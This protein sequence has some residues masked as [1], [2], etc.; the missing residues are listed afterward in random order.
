MT[1]LDSSLLDVYKKILNLNVL[2]TIDN[3]IYIYKDLLCG[4]SLNISQNSILNGNVS[5]VS[6]LYISNKTILEDVVLLNNNLYNLNHNTLNNITTNNNLIVSNNHITSNITVGG[7]LIS[8]NLSTNSLISNGLTTI[9]SNIYSNN[10]LPIT[11]SISLNS[12]ILN[13]GN[14]N[15][16]ININGTTLNEFSNELIVVD[17]L[18]SINV[19]YS[20]RSGI[21]IG[22]Q[23]GFEIYNSSGMGYFKTNINAD[24]YE[25]K[26]PIDNSIYNINTFNTN[27][28]MTITGST[29]FRNNTNIISNLYISSNNILSLNFTN[30]SIF[31]VSNNS[32]LN[33]QASI[34]KNISVSSFSL[35][36]SSTTINNNLSVNGN[37]SLN[38]KTVMSKLNIS[39]LSNLNNITISSSIII[40]NISSYN[41]LQNTSCMSSL[42]G[43]NLILKDNST[44]QTSLYNSSNSILLGHTSILSNC[45]I[46]GNTNIN[47]DTKLISNILCSGITFINSNITALSNINILGKITCPLKEYP[48]NSLATANGVPLWGFYRTGG[49]IKIRI[50]NISPTIILSGLSTIYLDTGNNYIDQGVSVTDNLNAN[51]IPYITSV[52][53]GTTELINNKIIANTSNDLSSIVNISSPSNCIITYKATDYEGNFSIKK[54]QLIINN[55]VKL[56]DS[57]TIYD[58]SSTIGN[59]TNSY[60]NNIYSGDFTVETWIYITQYLSGGTKI[61]N[62]TDSTNT[63]SF[64]IDNNGYVSLY[65]SPSNN[66]TILSTQIVPL[67]E[68]VHIVW[69]RKSGLVYSFINGIIS[70]SINLPSDF[71]SLSS[72]NNLN[73]GLLYGS[74]SQPL[75]TSTSKYSL[76]NFIP[77]IDISPLNNLN[78][79]FY[80]NN[81]QDSV[82]LSNISG[83]CSISS[84]YIENYKIAY[85][86]TSGYIGPISYGYTSMNNNWTIESW[87]YQIN[88][89]STQIVIDFR[90]SISQVT[91]PTGVLSFTINTSGYPQ[92]WIPSSNTY[93]TPTI[94]TSIPLNKWTHVV[95]MYTSSNLYTFINGIPSTSYATTFDITQMNSLVLSTWS[96]NKFN[97]M[98]SQPCITK[99]NV[100]NVNGFSPLFDLTPN[101][102]DTNIL[103]FIDNTNIERLTNNSI[104]YNNT[105]LVRYRYVV[106]TNL[107]LSNNNDN[108]YV[109]AYDFNSG[110]LG[111][112]IKD[113]TSVFSGSNN[114]TVEAWVY[115]TASSS[116]GQYYLVDFR[117]P[118]SWD[119]SSGTSG[120]LGPLTQSDSHTNKIAF[121]INNNGQLVI[122]YGNIG[123]LI[124]TSQGIKINEWNHVVWM[125]NGNS[126]NGIINGYC[127]N[128]TITSTESN[129]LTNLYT[130]TLGRSANYTN[131]TA[132][133]Q[134]NGYMSQ[135]LIR[136]G[137]QYSIST[138]FVPAADLSSLS[139][140]NNNT[141]FFLNDKYTD[142]ATNI[143]LPRRFTVNI[144]PRYISY[145]QSYDTTNGMLG[146]L[147]ND[148]TNINNTNWTIEGWIYQTNR[149]TSAYSLIGDFRNTT[150]S[151]TTNTLGIGLSINGYPSIYIYGYGLVVLSTTAVTLNTW[152]HVV[153]MRQNNKLYSFINGIVSNS[154]NIPSELNSLSNLKYILIG[155]SADQVVPNTRNY[156][157]LGKISQ[158]KV[159]MGSIYD[160][161]SSFTSS[162]DLL[163]NIT[164]I[165]CL[166]FLGDNNKD[167][168]TGL[169]LTRNYIVSNICRISI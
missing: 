95:W 35:L 38:N 103:F 151:A 2:T 96:T 112:E 57:Y 3:N 147:S 118:S 75:I 15:S 101:I 136:S 84:R 14:L 168:I 61:I 54:R 122:W 71:T 8:Y 32:I 23:S 79:L 34:Y 108:R 12:S 137:V 45:L 154:T 60:Y 70:S 78:I 98:I 74:I 142:V 72:I 40:G 58:N 146:S 47:S 162:K 155:G 124:I 22:D 141:I 121:T 163:Y 73:I 130:I 30:G 143:S 85:N 131:S 119:S 17:K 59:F 167:N 36:Q 93:I 133:Y 120:W 132:N 64:S 10:Y 63:I 41:I 97:G 18:I 92:V 87:L 140:S 128:T 139:I 83:N 164:D 76:S 21:D 123:N 7:T 158:F 82:S 25:L 106:N 138:P 44:I 159:T 56:Y 100:Y 165:I 116:S 42:Y 1:S 6:N 105:I 157:F 20:T 5:S 94:S 166:F 19:N 89:S 9:A 113:Y 4:S 48:T 27:Y 13:I 66:K 68:W 110:W 88:R 160:A 117:D 102:S 11:N 109:T 152:T 49:I 29:I 77:N 26:V 53:N 37:Y 33:D 69:M 129:N 91:N 55:F 28:D 31:N 156:Q 90:D 148:Y 126:Y 169:Q 114:Y 62:I 99:R 107:K 135:L 115:L 52:N 50:D 65:F 127:D 16:N 46:S 104:V 24:K 80:L 111:K 81:G 67:K 43:N 86:I 149:G 145:I 51:V 134:L 144:I 150:S 125:K 153:W 161:Y 39:N